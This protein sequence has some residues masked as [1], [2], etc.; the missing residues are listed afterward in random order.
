MAG[1][2]EPAAA[3]A[4]AEM[5]E[6]GPVAE[7]RAVPAASA[8]A[9][10]PLL[11]AARPAAAPA[12][13]A[14]AAAPA[15]DPGASLVVS[16]PSQRAAAAG[17]QSPSDEMMGESG[18]ALLLVPCGSVMAA[19]AGNCTLPPPGPAPASAV[20]PLS[21]PS[22]PVTP[23]WEGERW[24]F[25]TANAGGTTGPQPLCGLAGGSTPCCTICPGPQTADW[26]CCCAWRCWDAPPCARAAPGLPAPPFPLSGSP[27]GLGTTTRM[28]LR[29]TPPVD[30]ALLTAAE[31]AAHAPFGAAAAAAAVAIPGAADAPAGLVA[32]AGAAA[33]DG[34][35]DDAV[36]DLPAA[37]S[38]AGGP[39]DQALE[40][41]SFGDPTCCCCCC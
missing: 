17:A 31:P 1:V 6:V 18:A 33:A 4:A 37:N 32:G 25:T 36:G 7:P 2:S 39:L 10:L 41:R 8:G 28:L 13:P 23:C 19:P 40:D 26:S 3:A 5:R 22:A 11:H 21:A 35:G 34:G 12:A 15:S 29:N 14:P 9:A 20:A 27:A 30:G 24:L 38:P 16:M